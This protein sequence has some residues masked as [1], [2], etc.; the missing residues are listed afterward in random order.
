MHIPS[1]GVKKKAYNI[2]LSAYI[3]F[4]ISTYIT[5]NTTQMNCRG[6]Q[7]MAFSNAHGNKIKRSRSFS[8]DQFVL[9]ITINFVEEEEEKKQSLERE[10]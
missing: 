6:K 2:N 7:A 9:E 10:N 5:V 1:L 4:A 3:K 8:I